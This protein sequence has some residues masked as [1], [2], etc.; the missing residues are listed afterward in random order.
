MNTYLKK[1]LLTCLLVFGMLITACFHDT[2]YAAT[3]RAV[4]LYATYEGDGVYAP[5]D[6]RP[7]DFR[8]RVTYDDGDYDYLGTREFDMEVRS[9][10]GHYVARIT[11]GNLWYNVEL[12]SGDDYIDDN[13]P[14]TLLSIS[15]TYDG[16]PIAVGGMAIR[17]DFTVKATYRVYYGGEQSGSVG[18]V[19]RVVEDGWILEPHTITS[20][21]NVLTIT[22]SEDGVRRSCTVI[23]PS[24]GTKG[25]WIKDGDTWRFRYDDSTYLTGDWLKSGGKWYYFDEYGYMLNRVKTN[26]DGDTYYFDD[27]G[28]M[29]TGWVYLGRNWYYFGNNG[30]MQKGWIYTGGEWYYA[31][32]EGIMLT[33]WVFIDNNWYFMNSD[34]KMQTGW[35]HRNYTWF[36][37][38][39]SGAMQT[40]WVYTGGKWYFMDH[41]GAMLTNTWVGNNYVDGSGVWVSSR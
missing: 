20:G 32:N 38:N 27:A 11:Y 15:A 24:T 23:V 29:Q 17:R 21:D 10:G 13:T 34:G 16:D 33:D 31:D 14:R 25:N 39:D 12:E 1:G 41:G 18:R 5:D 37:L 22:Y 35:L 8:V 19:T 7:E 28:V 36:F 2:L 4:E 3:K 30:K 6:V 26:L 9:V 40:G